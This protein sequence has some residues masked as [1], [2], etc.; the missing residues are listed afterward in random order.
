[1]DSNAKAVIINAAIGSWYPKGQQRL[2]RSL[3]HHGFNWDIKTWTDFPNNNFDKSCPYHIKPAALEEVMKEGYTHVLWL[4]SS[5]WAISDPNKMFDIINTVGYY[6]GD[7]GGYTCAQTCN[8]SCLAYFGVSRDQAE[9]IP[10]CASG[11]LGLN[12]SNPIAKEFA[13]RWI[14]A[15]KDGAFKGSREHDN[16]SKDPRF[17][18]HRQDQSAA[19]LIA[20]S[21]GMK[22]TPFGGPVAYLESQINKETIFTLRGM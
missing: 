20:H 4:D 5:V 18:F 16:Q 14:K 6:L 22:L 7:S 11:I 10:D 2:V 1:M 12:L 3:I 13:T 19:S 21:L 9:S 8:D 15:G 17:Q